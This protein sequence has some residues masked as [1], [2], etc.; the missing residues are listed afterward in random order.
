MYHQADHRLHQVYI[1]EYMR[2][3]PAPGQAGTIFKLRRD[4][5]ITP[6]GGVLRRL[7]LDEIP[8]LVNVLKGEMSLVGPRP[9]LDYEIAHY[10][11]QHRLRLLVKPGITGLWQIRGRDVVDFETMITMDLDYLKRQSL[12]LDVQ[13]LVL[14]VPVL[15]WTYLRH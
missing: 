12:L 8:Q 15:L 7:G 13:I 9:A 4:P 11:A 1:R 6:L 10:N 14:T 3:R 5:R 2:G